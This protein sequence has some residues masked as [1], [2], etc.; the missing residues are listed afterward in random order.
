MKTVEIFKKCVFK[1]GTVKTLTTIKTIKKVTSVCSWL[2]LMVLAS[3][4][5]SVLADQ[6]ADDAANFG[7]RG[8]RITS[9]CVIDGGVLVIPQV[10]PPPNTVSPPHAKAKFSLSTRARMPAGAWT[11]VGSIQQRRSYIW[12]IATTVVLMY[13][14]QRAKR[15]SVR[16]WIC[17]HWVPRNSKLFARPTR[18]H[19]GAQRG[20]N[21]DKPAPT[22][23]WRRRWQYT[24]L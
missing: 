1:E 17:W 12:P 23:G 5:A 6:D 4:T 21:D 3:T 9:N 18:Q 24:S 13:S 8:N 10:P 19:S 15:R 7:V 14:I 20:I 11:L 2:M 16:R 22:L